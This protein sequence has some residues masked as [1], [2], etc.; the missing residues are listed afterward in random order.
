MALQLPIVSPTGHTSDYLRVVEVITQQ[1][2]RTS[3]VVVWVYKDAA[4]RAADKARVAELNYYWDGESYPF[5][6]AALDAE[7]MNH[8]KAAYEKLRTLPEYAGAVDV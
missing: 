4:A 1:A 2:V 8:V 5:D 3:R 6:L 7:G